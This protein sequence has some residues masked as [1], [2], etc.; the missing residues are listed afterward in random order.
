MG[1]DMDS[2]IALVGRN[3]SGKSTLLKL[4]SGELSPTSGYVLRN[5][6]LRFATFSQH[7]V[8]QLDLELSPLE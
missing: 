5:Q 2:R 8:D 1:I 6:K 3:G 4:F 7:F